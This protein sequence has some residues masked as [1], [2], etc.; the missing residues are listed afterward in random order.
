MKNAHT[1]SKKMF[2]IYA[3]FLIFIL[4]LA[5]CR[6]ELFDPAKTAFDNRNEQENGTNQPTDGNALPYNIAALVCEGDTVKST[7]AIVSDGNR[8]LGFWHLYEGDP[9]GKIYID[10]SG[11]IFVSRCVESNNYEVYSLKDSTI[12]NQQFD[13]YIKSFATE[14]NRTIL[15]LNNGDVF[16]FDPNGTIKWQKTRSIN[17]IN[18]KNIFTSSDRSSSYEV[19]FQVIDNGGTYEYKYVFYDLF[20]SNVISTINVEG[21]LYP[22]FYDFRGTSFWIG[23]NYKLMK[24]N[25]ISYSNTLYTFNDYAI[26]DD[27][28][29]F[30][31]GRSI[32]DY[33]IKLL[34]GVYDSMYTFQYYNISFD[35]NY[36]IACIESA[37]NDMLIIGLGN[38][39]T[40]NDGLY[41][42]KISTNELKKIYNGRV[43]D[44][45]AF[46]R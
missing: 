27:N 23:N 35:V 9:T 19:E 26:I 15:L 3:F 14:G 28:N 20:K 34:K 39:N 36:G 7:K 42:Y 46:I 8:I 41:T 21:N 11:W 24:G 12:Y 33:K 44:I 29:V 45:S 16:Q 32:S 13:Q 17:N 6:E 5:G 43:Y 1:H 22:I 4:L 2:F 25:Q 10:K 30:A 18:N 31:I 37:T 38:T 40:V